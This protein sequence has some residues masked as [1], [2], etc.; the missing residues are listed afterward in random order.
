MNFKTFIYFFL[1]IQLFGCK[2]SNNDNPNILIFLTDDQGWGDLSINGNPNLST[3]NIDEIAKNGARFE[4]FYV[5]P[6][7]SPTRAELLTGKFFLRSGVK[8]VTKGYERMN[9]DH[10]LISDFFKEKKYRTGLFGK[11]HNG[12]QP[13]YHPNSRGFEEFYGFTAGHWGN[14]FNPILEKN[15]KIINGKGYISDDITNNAI[16]FIKKSE[17][18]FFTFVS[19]NT[20]HSPMQVPESYVSN[21]KI[22]KQGRYAEKENIRKTEAALGMVEN[23]DYNVGKVIDSLKKYDLYKNTIII[24]FSD[25]GPNGNRWNNDLKE[26]KGSTNEGGVRVPFFIQWPS[27]I[28]KGIKINQITSVMDIFPTLVEL[29]NN[30]SNI[31]FDGKSFNQYLEDPYLKD[32]DRKIFSYWRNKIS[33]R[34]NNFILD[35]NDDLF[36]L[37]NDHKQEFR[38]NE[39][40][41][42]DYKELKKAKEQWKDSLVVP[43]NKLISKRRFTINY[44]DL[45]DTHLPA[46]DAEI[47]GILKRSSIHANC[48]FIENW[49]N[50]NDYIY[51]DLD[52]LNSGKANIDL[53]YTLPENSKG[54][55]IAIEY[56]NQIIYKTIDDFYDP[57][58]IGMEKDFVK[59]TESYTKEFKRI[60]IGDLY[61]KKGLSTLK[62]KTTKKIGE[63]SIDFRL[64]ILKKYNEKSS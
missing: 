7:C 64:L 48:S 59:R 41:I 22:I 5:S 23:L 61:F 58:L 32:N 37:N 29:T 2:Y 26:K 43:Y 50:E 15:G 14:Y 3:P 28:K 56:E 45:I 20:P 30:S 54:T 19:Y 55:E 17:E 34:N 10:K 1:L 44:T 8:G 42:N 16:S 31:E 11:W 49:K 52:V 25:N 39:N 38:V 9:V 13:P 6:V 12:S 47:T 4:R 60:N 24:F 62:I 27:K 53:Y 35:N 51:W 46:R 18:P 21:K 57:K 36:N 63:K 40:F 33:V